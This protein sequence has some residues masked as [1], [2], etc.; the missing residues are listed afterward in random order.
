MLSAKRELEELRQQPEINKKSSK[1]LN[2]KEKEYVPIHERYEKVI[3]ESQAKKSQRVAAIIEE[4][5][6]KDPDQF[7]PTFKPKTITD[8]GRPRDFNEFI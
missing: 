6:Q 2:D 1:L 4:A 8:N 5:V 7:F 3:N